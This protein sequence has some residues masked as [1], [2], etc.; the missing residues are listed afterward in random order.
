MSTLELHNVSKNIGNKKILK[1]ITFSIGEGEIVGFVGPNGAGKTTTMR[2]ITNLLYPNQGIIRICGY[3]LN[4]EREKALNNISAIVENPNLYNYLSGRENMEF[5]R[6][7]NHI[8]I[9]KMNQTIDLVGLSERIH[10]KVKKYSLG[11][12]QRLALG[13]C[14]ITDPKLL[15]LDEPTNGLDPSGTLELR[16][17]M[18]SRSREKNMSI[19]IS[20]HILS[21]I[22]KTCDRIIYIKDGCI[23][24]TVTNNRGNDYQIYSIKFEN[25]EKAMEVFEHC[26]LIDKYHVVQN[27][28]LVHIKKDNFNK[29]LKLFTINELDFISIELMEHN[30]DDEYADL[31]MDK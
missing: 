23:L 28:F 22:E 7:M 27:S 3:N 13:M 18:I 31:Y 2:L 16:N 14:L 10:D 6:K 26:S 12:K 4:K 30:I 17:L 24:S 5:I 21:E 19:F 20:S 15:I 25:V 9:D 8:S 29:L 1:D 11:M